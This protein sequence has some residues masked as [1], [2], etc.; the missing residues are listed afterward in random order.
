M[1]F[2]EFDHIERAHWF[3]IKVRV[4][5]VGTYNN[6]NDRITCLSTNLNFPCQITDIIYWKRIKS[7]VQIKLFIA[8]ED[9]RAH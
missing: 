6:N 8:E 1:Y 7:S 2:I 4:V 9:K 3:K 5:I